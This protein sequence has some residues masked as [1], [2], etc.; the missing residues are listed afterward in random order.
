MNL[1][2]KF[3]VIILTAGVATVISN[4]CRLKD[5]KTVDAYDM[6][7]EERMLLLDTN[8]I[9][10][11]TI[12]ASMQS[13]PVLTHEKADEW[14]AFEDEIETKLKSND[15]LILEIKAMPHPN[16]F[17]QRKLKYLIMENND[18]KIALD[19]F[20]D[21]KKLR[22]MKFKTSMVHDAN[23]IE[24]ELNGMKAEIK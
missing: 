12:D 11:E 3:L 10:Q 7:K 18:L 17:F 16:F 23:K 4:S 8:F 15:K 20:N 24:I 6:V 22:W 1:K 5:Q 13:Q 14:T 2:M 9:S 19:E 21:D